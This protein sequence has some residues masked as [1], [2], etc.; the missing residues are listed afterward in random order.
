MLM[1]DEGVQDALQSCTG[2]G[3]CKDQCAHGT[4]VGDLLFFARGTDA[5][6]D[7][8]QR[9]AHFLKTGDALGE[10]L[11]DMLAN[12]PLTSKAK[13]AYF[14]GSHR[15]RQ[16]LRKVQE[17]ASDE[18][19]LSEELKGDAFQPAG[20]A[21][22]LEAYELAFGEPLEL[23]D[24]PERIFC[25]GYPLLASG[26]WSAFVDH[27]QELT[28]VLYEF[29]MVVTSDPEIAHTLTTMRKRLLPADGAHDHEH[30]FPEVTT[31]VELL[32]TRASVFAGKSE[33]LKVRYHDP[34]YLG[35]R[36]GIYEAPRCLLT[37]ATGIP[38]VEF[39][40][41]HGDADCCGGGGMFPQTH[42]AEAAAL[43]H[44]RLAQEPTLEQKIDVLVTASPT[45]LGHFSSSGIPAVDVVDVLLGRYRPDHENAKCQERRGKADG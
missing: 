35:R 21:E 28:D 26:A 16:E 42:P 10:P 14:P 11:H 40:R 33:G 30:R 32:A 20:I 31:L 41:S 25:S 5:D 44:K 37:S 17:T 36:G 13:V 4:P 43:A 29:E 2:C 27:Q 23:V 18:G 6:D 38:P 24:F 39:V 19:E 15:L 7:T 45:C 3:A 9:V 34:C 12:F 1:Q 8:K 22:D